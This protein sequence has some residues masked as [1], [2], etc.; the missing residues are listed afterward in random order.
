MKKSALS[1]S[2]ISSVIF[3]TG[4]VFK[5]FHLP[6]AAILV[7]LGA[8]LGIGFLLIY[9]ANGA[10]N[11]KSGMEKINGRSASLT[12]IVILIGFVFK[13]QHWPGAN[14]LLVLAHIFLLISA[15]LMY[16]DALSETDGSTRQLKTLFAF[17]Y[18]IFMSILV[19][20]AI[21]FNGFQPP[22]N[23]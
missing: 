16:L 9:F 22:L 4:I 21:F 23:N 2:M 12:M 6:G 10:K 11:L 14:V 3:F 1:L 15:V 5:K 7:L 20:L 17:I 19:Y 18:F 13:A 8:L